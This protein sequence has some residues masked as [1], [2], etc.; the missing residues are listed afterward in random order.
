[1]GTSSQFEFPEI[2]QLGNL[3]RHKGNLVSPQF[4]V[5]QVRHAK[6]TVGNMREVVLAE[7]ECGE[8]GEV[9][10]AIRQ[11]FDSALFQTEFSEMGEIPERIWQGGE[12]IVCQVDAG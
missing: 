6:D 8:I 7:I 1:M 2:G 5:H 12:P 10:Q 9:A 11:R 4:K 3:F